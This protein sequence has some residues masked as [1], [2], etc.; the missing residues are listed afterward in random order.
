MWHAA[1]LDA[2]NNDNVDVFG[3]QQAVDAF[4]TADQVN[5]EKFPGSTT[6]QFNGELLKCYCSHCSTLRQHRLC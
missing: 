6:S 2:G 5:F 4:N 3:N 1:G